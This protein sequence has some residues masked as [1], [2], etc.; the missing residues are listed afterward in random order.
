[1]ST[2]DAERRVDAALPTATALD[3]HAARVHRLRVHLRDLE[4][5]AVAFSG[6]VDSSVLLHAA[7]RELGRAAVGVIA[8]SPSLPRRELAEARELARTIGAELVELST[9]EMDDERYLS[10]RGDRCYFCKAA[11]FTAMSAWA[12]ERGFR[13]LA[14]GEITDD[15]LDDRPGARAALEFGVVAPLSRAGFSKDDVR[16]YARDAGLAVADKPSS[17]C[18][19]S[20]LSV[21]TSV[22]RERLARIEACEEDLRALGLR[23]LRV[24]DR[25][26][27]ARVEVGGDELALAR[28]RWSVIEAALA[29]RGFA[30]AEL[31][32]YLTPAQRAMNAR[33]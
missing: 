32:E 5:V 29:R 24:R 15:R 18:L 28:D 14:F 10:N 6:G 31:D 11:L 17:A 2:D 25:G 19:A 21:G 16:R 30:C 26:D 13:A 1:M 20:R 27:R 12:R 7:V 3:D 9:E 22:T 8:D 23:Q 4:R 33:T